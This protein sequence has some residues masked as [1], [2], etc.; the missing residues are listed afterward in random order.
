MPIH[1]LT[2]D[3]AAK[4]AA[5]EVVERP[6]SVA[7]EL[8]ENAIDAGADDIRLEITQGG[9]A[10]IRVS[11]NGSGIPADE[12][13]LAFA[14]HATSKLDSADDLYRIRTLGFRGEALA[15][16]ASVS[17]L[18]L[19]TQTEHEPAGT[20]VR[21]EGGELVR[22]EVSGR[23]IGTTVTVENL[24]YNMPAR[25]KFLR[26]DT[27]EAGHIARLVTSYAL[28]CPAIRFSL[29]NNGRQVLRTLGTGRLYDSLV[30]L[31]GLEVAE[32]MMPIN[33]T[34]PDQEAAITGYIG[35]PSLHRANRS[36]II[37]FV[38]TRWVQDNALSFAVIEG[39]R[40][41]LPNGRYP[42]AVIQ[43]TLPPEDVDVNIHPT[44][45]EVRFRRGHELF[46]TVQR[47]VRTQ[48]MSLHSMP[49]VSSI[50]QEDT[51]QRRQA[52][53]NLGYSSHTGNTHTPD[54]M[55][56]QGQPQWHSLEPAPGRLPM[57]RVLG[58]I[59]QTYIIAEGPGGMYLIDQ[60]AAAERVRFE[61]LV[62]QRRAHAVVSQELLDPL[63]L[64][65]SPEQALLLES[66]LAELDAYGLELMP[67]GGN[68]M[69]VKRIPINLQGQ[70]V[71]GMLL[72][73]LDAAQAQGEAFLWDEQA[74][75]MLAC[76]TAIRAGQVLSLEEMRELL[77]LLEEAELPHS[78]PHGR[79]T[80]VHMSQA[81]LEKE[82]SRR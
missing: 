34:I 6:V 22:R 18:T 60:H 54:T 81:Q 36:D 33:G 42:L 52:L 70:D 25:L 51:L 40:T 32:Q 76:H 79:P 13:E 80:M 38:N 8:L 5:G 43:I 41:L 50:L 66:H 44:K 58:Q 68:T 65:F 48:L 57:L 21:Y 27:T 61:E 77:R 72:E 16:I 23:T 82:F 7:K 26:A 15:S 4:I 73:M 63:P 3:V 49:D 64:E 19:I 20:L 24:F 39:Y 74:L 10:L 30:A 28:A 2:P 37:L 31:Y 78:C 46:S 56:P 35:Y 17:R 59:A 62:R 75:I 1:Q 47:T 55:L 14:R 53:M 69:L 71:K 67:F 45:R 9:R 12:V 11:D 29:E